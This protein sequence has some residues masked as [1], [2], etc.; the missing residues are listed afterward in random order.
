MSA[1]RPDPEPGADPG[2]LRQRPAPPL[3]LARQ[4]YRRRRIADAARLL[5]VMGVVLFWL[6]L[7]GAGAEAQAR[8][9]ASGGVYLFTVW[10]GLIVAAA[11]L[12]RPLSREQTDG[13][14]GHPSSDPDEAGG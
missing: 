10:A 4:T 5:P 11:L 7:L 3:F 12:A 6:P 8:R 1:P 2:L 9:A 13:Q 14:P